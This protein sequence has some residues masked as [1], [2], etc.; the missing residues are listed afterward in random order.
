MK[1]FQREFFKCFDES[2]SDEFFLV[3]VFSYGCCAQSDLLH[4]NYFNLLKF[5]L[6]Q[7]SFFSQNFGQQSGIDGHFQHCKYVNMKIAYVRAT[8]ITTDNHSTTEKLKLQPNYEMIM[9]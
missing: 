5:K 4:A 3:Y 1:F 6:A 7:I 2:I 9:I 8:A